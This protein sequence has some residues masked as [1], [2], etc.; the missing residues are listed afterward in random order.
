MGEREERDRYR[1]IKGKASRER[2]IFIER[3]V[4]KRER[5][6][7]T[8]QKIN[9]KVSSLLNMKASRLYSFRLERKILSFK[10]GFILV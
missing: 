10:R 7:K 9:H 3:K 6:H 8:K 5:E 2:Y 4:R 1:R